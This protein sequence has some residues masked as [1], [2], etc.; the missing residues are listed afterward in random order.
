[1]AQGLDSATQLSS[2]QV[3]PA[4]TPGSAGEP[5]VPLG[6]EGWAGAH[7]PGVFGVTDTA[8]GSGTLGEQPA[9]QGDAQ[10]STSV[11]REY[12]INGKRK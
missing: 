8:A 7:M 10:A 11:A 2:A 3:A 12:T 9:V 4:T 1:M 6:M 5:A